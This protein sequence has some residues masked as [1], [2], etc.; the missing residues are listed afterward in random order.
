[1]FYYWFG[2]F[3]RVFRD[4]GYD[5]GYLNG[6]PTAVTWAYWEFMNS[7]DTEVKSVGGVAHDLVKLFLWQ[8]PGDE[9]ARRDSKKVP[10]R[11]SC[12]IKLLHCHAPRLT[13]CPG[14]LK[15]TTLCKTNLRTPGFTMQ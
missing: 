12:T 14:V 11:V 6:T 8:L 3:I 9:Q 1:M 4:S 7:I 5:Q 13:Y 10:A 2:V 15:K